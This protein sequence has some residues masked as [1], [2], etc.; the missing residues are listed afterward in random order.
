M[1]PRS[2]YFNQRT[3][4]IPSSTPLHADYTSCSHALTSDGST[5]GYLYVPNPQTGKFDQFGQ[6]RQ[7]WQFNLGAQMS[8]DVTPRITAKF[9]VANIVN[10]CFGGS[11]TAWTQAYPPNGYTCAYTTN[12][13]Y[14]G[15]NFFQGK[16]PNDIRA[17]GVAENPYFAQPFVPSYGD[18][19]SGNFPLA[20]NMYFS[21][22]VK[23]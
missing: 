21:V 3:S 11:T 16:S 12:T 15:A 22:N 13:F 20:L 10:T 6:F 4:G 18:P 19:F 9:V 1:D 14:N 2:C 8:Y 7:P 17:N 23:L 5:P